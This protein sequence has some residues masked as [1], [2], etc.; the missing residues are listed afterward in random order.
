MNFQE[1]LV[2]GSKMNKLR[3]HWSCKS[4]NCPNK[5]QF[6]RNEGN[7]SYTRAARGLVVMGI[8]VVER[9]TTPVGCLVPFRER[10][11]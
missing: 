1:C 4:P 10:A 3:M 9:V 8:M 7:I 11:I 6:V 5:T 2:C